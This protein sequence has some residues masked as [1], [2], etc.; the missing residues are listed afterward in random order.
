MLQK[1]CIFGGLV[2]LVLGVGFVV[3]WGLGFAGFAVVF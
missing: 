2:G 3:A 1:C